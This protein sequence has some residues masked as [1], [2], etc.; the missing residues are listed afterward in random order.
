[1]TGKAYNTTEAGCRGDWRFSSGPPFFLGGSM[2][3]ALIF[4]IGLILG[5]LLVK[6]GVV[7]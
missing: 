5:I 3:P 7:P 1:M 6:V 4:V 2:H